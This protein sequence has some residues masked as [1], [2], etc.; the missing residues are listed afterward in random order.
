MVRYWFGPSDH[1]DIHKGLPYLCG[2]VPS[3]Y[4]ASTLA[5]DLL[6]SMRAA[7]IS[8]AGYVLKVTHHG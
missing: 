1:N 3:Y 4:A 2:I 6:A 5:L 8:S 7:G